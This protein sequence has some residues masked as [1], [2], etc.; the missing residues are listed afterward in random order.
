MDKILKYLFDDYKRARSQLTESDLSYCNNILSADDVLRAHYLV[1]DYF[2]LKDD[3]IVLHGVKNINL[4]CSAVSRQYVSLHGKLKW[5]NQLEI[6]ATL[7]FGLVKNHAFHDGNKR[8][9]LLTMLYH[10]VKYNRIVECKQRD[11]EELTVRVAANELNK[12]YFYNKYKQDDDVEI[13]TIAHFLK[14]NTHKADKRFYSLT[15]SELDSKLRKFNC[16]LDKPS[17]GFINVF[18]PIKKYFRTSYT[19]V[20]QIGFPGWRSQVGEKALKEVLKKTKLTSE[21]GIDSQTFYE[22]N[23]PMYKL[24]QDYEGPLKRLKDK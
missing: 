8:T 2:L 7:Y 16:Y 13:K 11:F 9:A 6:V 12:Y 18:A 17:G 22:G 23:E 20:L 4:L 10:L 5:E 1:C 21:N 3:S 15:Y 14:R 24:I 19:P